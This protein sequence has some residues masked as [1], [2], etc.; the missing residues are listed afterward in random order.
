MYGFVISSITPNYKLYS[1]CNKHWQT[2]IT[3]Y[4]R[5]YVG[6][7]PVSAHAEQVL[8]PTSGFTQ[9]TSW[10]MEYFLWTDEQEQFDSLAPY[11]LAALP[12]L[13]GSFPLLVSAKH[14]N[15]PRL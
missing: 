14:V 13:V 2:T 1:V 3:G 15:V 10:N 8:N 5:V 6:H 4:K 9:L 7:Y 12:T 11:L